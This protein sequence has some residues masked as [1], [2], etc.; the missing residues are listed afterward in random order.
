MPVSL[1]VESLAQCWCV[2]EV[3]VVRHAN[4]V[5]A[6]DI[7]RLGF[8]VCTAASG[9][10]SQMSETHEARKVRDARAV[11]KNLGGHTVTLAL[12]KASTSAAT[13]NT[14]GILAAM[15]EEVE[16]IVHLNRGRLRLWITVDHRNDTAH[17]DVIVRRVEV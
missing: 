10:V 6:I 16:G 4:A 3:S 17:I 7:E 8:S 12:V 15:L 5:W 9:G 14:S 13:D 2:D 11:L 1:M